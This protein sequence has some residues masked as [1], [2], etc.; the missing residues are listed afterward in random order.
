MTDIYRRLLER[1][2][3]TPAVVM[4]RR[5]SLPVW[6]KVAIAWRASRKAP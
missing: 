6:Q 3:R 4:E 1:I 5:V 2:S